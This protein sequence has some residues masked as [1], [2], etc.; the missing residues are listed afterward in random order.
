MTLNF[1]E[2]LSDN[3]KAYFNE[4]LLKLTISIEILY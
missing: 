1:K 2:K 3:V 4:K